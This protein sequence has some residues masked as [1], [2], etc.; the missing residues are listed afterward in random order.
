MKVDLEISLINNEKYKSE[1]INQMITSLDT[2]EKYKDI[3]YNRINNNLQTR[4]SKLCNL[5]SRI[6]RILQIISTLPNIN[7]AI[8]LKSKFHYPKNEDSHYKP[9]V[10]EKFENIPPPGKNNLK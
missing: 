8:T 10:I 2:M 6:N 7:K 9:T 5:K 1:W 4:V 3:I